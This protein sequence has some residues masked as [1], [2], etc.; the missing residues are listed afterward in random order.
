MDRQESKEYVCHHL[1][2]AGAASSIFTDAALDVMYFHSKGVARVK[3]CPSERCFQGS[4][5]WS[6]NVS[7]IFG[8]LI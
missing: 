1:K 5:L 6:N 2:V 3:P 8:R 7:Q 4:G